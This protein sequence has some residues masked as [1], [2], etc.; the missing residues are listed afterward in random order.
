MLSRFVDGV[1]IKDRSREREK[2]DE[3]TRCEDL[4][5]AARYL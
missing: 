3:M 5:A 4:N 2:E 1:Y